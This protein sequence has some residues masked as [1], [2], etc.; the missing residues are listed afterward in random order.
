MIDLQNGEAKSMDA[1]NSDNTE[2]YHSWSSNGRWVVF[3]SRR[4]DGVFTRPFIAHVDAQGRASKPFELPSEN[5]DY[6][7][8]LIKSYNVPELMRG[9]VTFTPQQ[10]ADILKGESTDVKEISLPK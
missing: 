7:Q 5:P 1:L 10:M 8:Q 4:N 6:H 2:S 9:P 3:S